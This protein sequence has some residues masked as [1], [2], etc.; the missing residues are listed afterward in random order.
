MS[1]T[2]KLPICEGCE[3]WEC[4]GCLSS[5]DFISTRNHPCVQIVECPCTEFN[6]FI[7]YH[8]DACRRAYSLGHADGIAQRKAEEQANETDAYNLGYQDGY[9]ARTDEE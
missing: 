2:G 8:K 7:C 9:A 1:A 3:Q 6:C 5:D 4:Q